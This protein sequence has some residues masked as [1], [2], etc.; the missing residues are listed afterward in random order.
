MT[1]PPGEGAETGAA[2]ARRAACEDIER[3]MTEL[4]RAAPALDEG[5][6]AALIDD[7]RGVGS[8]LALSIARAV[9]LVAEGLIAQGVALPHLAMACATLAAEAA[10]RLTTR[11]LEAARYEIDTLL[12]VPDPPGGGPPIRPADIRI[13]DVP[14]ASLSR[15]PRRRT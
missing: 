9:E 6:V 12:P 11:E 2:A 3:R 14:L 15:G 4:V 10:G 13:P 1:S 7:L 8:P 5:E